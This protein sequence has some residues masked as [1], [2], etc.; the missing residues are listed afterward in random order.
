MV[1]HHLGLGDHFVCNGLVRAVLEQTKAKR[2]YLPTKENNMVTVQQMYSDDSRIVCLPVRTDND[3]FSLPENSHTNGFIRAG[4]EKATNFEWDVSFY[5]SVNLPWEIRWSK[6]SCNRNRESEKVLESFL[7]ISKGDKFVLV[8]DQGSFEQYPI[9]VATDL[10]IVKVMPYTRSMLD[11]CGL[12][13]KAEEV[14]CTDSSFVHL[15]QCLNVRKGVFHNNRTKDFTFSL[16]SSWK[17][18]D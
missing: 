4:F 8:H 6:F 15:A 1:Y 3:V 17:K 14:H 10:R 7:K 2:L 11:W 12:A 13:E 16:H 18:G 5:K 9:E